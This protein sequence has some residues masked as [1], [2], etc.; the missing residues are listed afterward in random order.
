MITVVMWVI[1]CIGGFVLSVVGGFF[2]GGAYGAMAGMGAGFLMF[3][4]VMQMITIG[5]QKGFLPLYVGLKDNEKYVHFPDK[6]RK[7]KTIIANTRHEGVCYKKGIGFI[8]DKGTEFSWGGD[9]A[10]FGIPKLGMTA[11]I[12]NASF[13]ELL[14]KNRDI[15][16]YDEAI[17]KY[18]GDEKYKVFCEKYRNI[19]KPNIHDINKELDALINVEKPADPLVEKVFGETWSFANFARFLKYAYHPL[20][21][22]IAVDSEKLWVKQ[23][24]M[25]YKDADRAMGWAKAVVWVLF[26]LMI[27]ISVLSSLNIKGFGSMFGL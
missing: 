23:E 6:F 3:M 24:M 8:D 15:K 18:L 26:G 4:P 1:L 10:S 22:D 12:K 21:M 20:A 9:P 11:E 14:E 25:G 2:F 16:D 19:E 13:T 7:L 17:R 5:K 27:F